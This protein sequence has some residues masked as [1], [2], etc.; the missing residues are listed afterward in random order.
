MNRKRS[1]PFSKQFRLPSLRCRRHPP[2]LPLRSLLRP[3]PQLP[4]RWRARSLQPAPDSAPLNSAPVTAAPITPPP[5]PPVRQPAIPAVVHTYTRDQLASGLLPPSEWGLLLAHSYSPNGGWYVM[6][7]PEAYQMQTLSNGGTTHFS[8]WS[9]DRHVPLGFYGAPFTPG[10]YHGRVQPVDL[11]AT[12]ASLLGV[13]QP[14]ASVGNVLTQAIH[15]LPSSSHPARRRAPGQPVK[16]D[17]SVRFAGHAAA[18]P[19]HCC[20]RNLRLW[21]RI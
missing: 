19:S 12:L 11:A 14:S 18:Q 6:V 9:Y 4:H 1:R 3:Q 20:Q 5:P 13:T 8:P 2:H 15:T 17:M 10:I 16:P 7:I 21:S